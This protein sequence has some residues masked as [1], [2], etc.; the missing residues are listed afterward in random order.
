M[1]PGLVQMEIAETHVGIWRGTLEALAICN[2]LC[3]MRPL[4]AL[5]SHAA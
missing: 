1:K 2:G 5:S 3:A 4:A